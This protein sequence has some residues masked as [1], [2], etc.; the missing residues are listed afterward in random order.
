[1]TAKD[2]L[3]CPD[4]LIELYRQKFCADFFFGDCGRTKEDWGINASRNFAAVP[5]ASDVAK[6]LEVESF[7]ALH[8]QT[9]T[10]LKQWV[11]GEA[12]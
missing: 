5:C 7:M 2:L 8:D 11:E 3:E 12:A 1:M 9:M 10:A 6:R 4:W